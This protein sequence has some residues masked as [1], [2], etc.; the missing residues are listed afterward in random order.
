VFSKLGDRAL[1]L[2]RETTAHPSFWNE[3]VCGACNAYGREA[4][5]MLSACAYNTIRLLWMP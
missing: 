4:A 2:F 1:A 5:R 3:K